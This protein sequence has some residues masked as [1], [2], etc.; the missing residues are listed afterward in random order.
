MLSKTCTKVRRGL[1]AS[2]LL[3]AITPAV[4]AQSIIDARRVEFTPSADHNAT[5]PTTGAALVTNYTLQVFVAGGT[6]AVSTA[7]LGKPAP[8]ADG[9]IRLDYVALLT[10]ALTP[11]VIYES[12]VSAVGPGGSAASAR[13]NTFAFSAPCAPSISPTSSNLTTSSAVTGNVTV[14][15]ATGCTWTSTSNA[16]WI[17]ITAG[18]SGSGNGSVGYSVAANT[19]TTSRTGTLTIAGQTF[20]VTQPGAPCTFTISPTSS[21]LTTSAA[22]TGTVNVTAGSGCS[23]TAT[24]NATSWITIS[25]GAS[26]SGNGSVSYSVAANTATTSRTGTMTI[27]GQTFTVTQAAAPCAFSVSP[28]SITAPPSGASGTI[29]VTTSSNCSWTTSSNATWAT[30]TGSRTGSG[31]ATY[32]IAANTG[33]NSR[34]AVFSVGGVAISVNQA[35]ATAPTPPAAPSNLRVVK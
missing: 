31:T 16:A 32:T 19:G 33:T 18:A 17:T 35:A 23:W 2:F 13:S 20:T 27:G 14:T 8:E 1:F 5:D 11:G 22:T 7:N 30:I 24:S 4:S 12:V 26:G 29:T 10:T 25:A 9:M 3:L 34:S 15:A 21:N 6:I 28:T